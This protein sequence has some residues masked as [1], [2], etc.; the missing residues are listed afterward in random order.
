[1]GA[2]G[3]WWLFRDGAGVRVR[4]G[5]GEGCIIFPQWRLLFLPPRGINAQTLF[6][7]GSFLL[8]TI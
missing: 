4:V 6:S 5:A 8:R 1:M 3:G 7:L 2:E